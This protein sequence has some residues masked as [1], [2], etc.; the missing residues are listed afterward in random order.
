MQARLA[1]DRT[2]GLPE[3]KH[4]FAP[5][6][7]LERRDVELAIQHWE[8]NTWGKDCVPLLDTFDFS[9]MK[10]SWG[11]RFLICGGRAVESSVFVAYGAGFAR[12]LGLP[13][14]PVTTI[15]FIQ[16]VP[17]SHCEMFSEGCS[18]SM[19]ESSPVTLEWTLGFG[20]GAQLF[21]A[22]FMP[23]MLRPNWSKQL[24][25]G[26]FNCRPAVGG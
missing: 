9:P 12:L 26:S 7:Q 20:S 15:P 14:K 21:R 6:P 25:F 18:K 16:Q 24:I 19:M 23:I 3:L 1:K 17:A 22:V 2:F 10:A 13:A 8:R 5:E 4:T 11:H